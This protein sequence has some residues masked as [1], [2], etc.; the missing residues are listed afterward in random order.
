MK[1]YSFSIACLPI[2]DDRT[3]DEIVDALFEAGCDDALIVERAGAFVLEFDREAPTFARALFSA[4]QAVCAVQLNPIRVEPDPLVSAADIASRSGL[5]RQAVS[6][7][8]KGLRGERFPVPVVRID[9]TSPLWLWSDVTRW[10][11][12]TATP[13]V[14]QNETFFARWIETANHK[15][16]GVIEHFKRDCAHTH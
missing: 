3:N 8:V 11:R 7:Y 16:P 9:T 15:L 5:T 10:L 13:S 12:G 6:N 2:E 14:D 1:T 4:L